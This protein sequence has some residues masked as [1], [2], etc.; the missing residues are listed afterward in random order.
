MLGLLRLVRL[1]LFLYCALLRVLVV[2]LD[3]RE[4]PLDLV[5]A[6]VVLGVVALV[7]PRHVNQLLD[8]VGVGL[9]LGEPQ[10]AFRLEAVHRE[11]LRL[12]LVGDLD[13]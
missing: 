5:D 4:Q 6:L 2:L 3:V 9:E 12:V 11:D 10:H 8:L 13:L 1:D 7:D